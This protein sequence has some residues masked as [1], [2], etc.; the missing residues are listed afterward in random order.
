MCFDVITKVIG[1][2]DYNSSDIALKK[3]ESDRILCILC[4]LQDVH[5]FNHF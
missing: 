2:T 4:D 3:L 5:F 1:L